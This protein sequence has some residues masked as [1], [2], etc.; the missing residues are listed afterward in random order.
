M[1]TKLEHILTH[2][3]KADMIS[4]I[5]LHPEEFDELIKLAI[6]D[7]KPYSWRAAWVLWGCMDINDQRL[8]AYVEEIIDRLPISSDNQLRELLN[9]LQR[10]DVHEDYE[11]KLFD[12][13]IHIWEKKKKQA[14]VRY[15]AFKLAVK[16]IKKHPDLSN[17]ILLITE[18]HYMDTLSDTVQ[19][20]IFKM[21]KGLT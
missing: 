15:N 2:S 7:K 9:V 14:S 5:K 19:K 21:I 17:E 18:P 6:A 13:C 10:M 4:Y 12:I 3:Y 11:G 8:H 20:S 1:E 16:I